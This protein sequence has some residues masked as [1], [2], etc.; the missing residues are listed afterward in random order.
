[1]PCRDD[2]YWSRTDPYY[3]SRTE[4][5]L[6]EDL[7]TLTRICCT[8]I[9]SLDEDTRNKI[10]ASDE[11]VAEWWKNHL[12]EDEQRLAREAEE[13]RKAK[14]QAAA[15]RKQAAANKLKRE[16][17]ELKEFERLKKKF[18]SK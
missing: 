7:D 13:K 3:L 15:R 14:E 12:L 10:I 4:E 8:I 11:E 5:G 18:E 1:M 6:E 17:K 2:V 9:K 16:A